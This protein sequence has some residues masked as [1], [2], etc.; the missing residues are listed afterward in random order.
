MQAGAQ[1]DWQ[2]G[3]IADGAGTGAAD[4]GSFSFSGIARAAFHSP[5]ARLNKG[6]SGL[7]VNTEMNTALSC[8]RNVAQHVSMV[9]FARA[10]LAAI[11][12]IPL[13]LTPIHGFMLASGLDTLM[14]AAYTLLAAAAVLASFLTPEHLATQYQP[15]PAP[16]PHLRAAYALAWFVAPLLTRSIDWSAYA[17]IPIGVLGLL[18]VRNLRSCWCCDVY[19]LAMLFGP[20]AAV[21]L[22]Y[23]LDLVDSHVVSGLS[24]SEWSSRPADAYYFSDGVVVG[25][26]ATRSAQWSHETGTYTRSFKSEYGV[27]PI[28]ANRSCIVGRGAAAGAATGERA[29]SGG[30]FVPPASGA[31]ERSTCEVRLIA[32][33][34]TRWLEPFASEVPD[35][36]EAAELAERARE[37]H[38]P[39]G[40]RGGSP[41]VTSRV[42]TSNGCARHPHKAASGALCVY[43]DPLYRKRRGTPPGAIEECRTLLQLHSLGPPSVCDSQFFIL[44]DYADN[45]RQRFIY[46]L[47]FASTAAVAAVAAYGIVGKRAG[48]L[49]ARVGAPFDRCWMYTN[50]IDEFLL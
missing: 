22:G 28:V 33:Y 27:A 42:V 4:P 48:W 36:A 13:I 24:V 2:S 12:L 11:V 31:M 39:S 25:E 6:Q 30:A 29:G 18:V 14:L 35:A 15:G 5:A 21:T 20:F 19:T 38:R 10:G 46:G 37:E 26:W 40:T 23:T 1:R 43:T 7:L 44:G 8:L 50:N 9:R 34:S 45:P 17:T 3:A 47:T 49:R 32:M 16:A 41:G